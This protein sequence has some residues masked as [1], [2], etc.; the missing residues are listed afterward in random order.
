MPFPVGT[1]WA[2][3][4]SEYDLMLASLGKVQQ[5]LSSMQEECNLWKARAESAARYIQAHPASSKGP[6]CSPPDT[7]TGRKADVD[8][9]IRTARSF[10]SLRS[11]DFTNEQ[12]KVI[13]ATTFLKGPDVDSW[14]DDLLEHRI[15]GMTFSQFLDEFRQRFGD[16]DPAETAR[17]AIDSLEQGLSSV[18]R[19]VAAFMSH[20]TKTGYNDIALVSSFKRGLSQPVSHLIHGHLGLPTTLKA[21]YDAAIWA[22]RQIQQENHWVAAAPPSHFTPTYHAATFPVPAA[23]LYRPPALRTPLAQQIHTAHMPPVQEDFF[24]GVSE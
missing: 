3:A 8:S 24:R 7:F 9:F 21:W 22:E 5:K 13:W 14:V 17:Q 19:Y 6:K 15:S 12:G 2:Q 23:P 4:H 18:D 20:A 11:S 10:T 16:H 1:T